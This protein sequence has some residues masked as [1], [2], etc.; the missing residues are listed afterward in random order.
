[1]QLLSNHG[2]NVSVSG[3]GI[4]VDGVTNPAG[5][6]ILQLNA[7]GTSIINVI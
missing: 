1:M 6:V 2:T 7:S 5:Q 4:S 3:G